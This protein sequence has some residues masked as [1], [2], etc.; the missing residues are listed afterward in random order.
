[1]RRP[2]QAPPQARCN[3]APASTAGA[4]LLAA[5]L[6]V[7]GCGAGGATLESAATDPTLTSSISSTPVDAVQTSDATTIRNAVS[8]IDLGGLEGQP[9]PWANADTGSRGAITELA[10]YSDNGRL[11]RRF[12]A[13]RESYDGVGLFRGE[14]CTAGSGL[15]KVPSL[16]AM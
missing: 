9:L 12:L 15:W 8:S 3:S 4:V 10:E 2:T 7:A 13:S 16:K 1:M 14:T 5:N 11:C 6:L